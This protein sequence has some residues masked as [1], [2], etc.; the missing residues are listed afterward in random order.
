[1]NNT[2]E[3]LVKLYFI[4]FRFH[5][6]LH[7]F[8]IPL[9][10]KKSDHKVFCVGTWK[11]GTTS[12]YQSLTIL[13]YRTGRLL[14]GGNKPKCGWIEYIK[15]SNYD[16]F[17]DDPI[18]FLYKELDGMYPNSKFILTIRDKESYIKSYYNY[19]EGTELEKKPEEKEKILKEYDKHNNEV[20]DY[21]KGRPD[22][23]LTINV[24]G[25]DG[26][27]KLCNFLGKPIPETPFPHKNKG[28]YKK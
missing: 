8:F 4:F 28:R 2:P 15:K 12:I 11:T 7:Q 25:G 9:L 18:S 24:V 17:T 14:R 6:K 23:L 13:G 19:F 21:F 1:M 16:A 22:K 3:W 26:W 10:K 5:Q 20:K 27:E